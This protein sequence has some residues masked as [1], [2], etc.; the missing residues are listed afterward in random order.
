MSFQLYLDVAFD[1][2]EKV[3]KLDVSREEERPGGDTAQVILRVEE[4]ELDRGTAPWVSS[5]EVAE[6][7]HDVAS[8]LHHVLM[9][10]LGLQSLDKILITL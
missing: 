6:L 10:C 7:S 4:A 3:D 1:F 5:Y 8:H 9:H 2:R